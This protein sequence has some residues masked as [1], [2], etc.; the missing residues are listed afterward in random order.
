MQVHASA[1]NFRDVMRAMGLYPAE[2]DSVLVGL[3]A[4]GTVVRANIIV[5]INC[6]G[7][8]RTRSKRLR[9]W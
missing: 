4:A 2:D 3:E 9:C 7:C 8:C 6:V 5:K 1:M